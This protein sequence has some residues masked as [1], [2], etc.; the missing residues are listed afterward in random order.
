MQGELGV[1]EAEQSL[2][3]LMLLA[4]VVKAVAPEGVELPLTDLRAGSCIAALDPGNVGSGE[5]L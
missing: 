3:V 2:R 1:I 5:L 4:E